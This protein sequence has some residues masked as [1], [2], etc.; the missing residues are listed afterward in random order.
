MLNV[1]S[2][3]TLL[4]VFR[5]CTPSCASS[6]RQI[7]VLFLKARR[8]RRCF[9][10]KSSGGKRF[11]TRG[12]MPS[13]VAEFPARRLNQNPTKARKPD[14]Y[15]FLFLISLFSRPKL[16]SNGMKA[17][18]KRKTGISVNIGKFLS[19]LVAEK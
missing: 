16:I 13:S 14:Y 10:G 8:I 17:T 4:R 5:L 15:K 11:A 2:C 1:P 18:G 3:Y 12:A 6:R 19:P 9:F 7:Y